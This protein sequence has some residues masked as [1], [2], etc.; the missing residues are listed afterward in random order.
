[1]LIINDRVYM[2]EGA[3][4]V[5][6]GAALIKGAKSL[7]ISSLDIGGPEVRVH[8][9]RCADG[10][11]PDDETAIERI[12]AEV[13]RLP[14]S[15][16]AYYRH[17][18]DPAP[19]FHPAHELAG[20]LP[21]DHRMSYAAEELLPRLVDHSLFWEL[22]PERGREMI[23]CVGRVAGLYLGFVA[24]RQGLMDDPDKR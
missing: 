5:I 21:S 2:T 23:V 3:Y 24:N 4:M 16:E 17:G 10:R 19:P 7:H 22:W 14:S 6:A 20:L 18:A 1:M 13:A 15:G 11:V 12:R 8:Q 9:S